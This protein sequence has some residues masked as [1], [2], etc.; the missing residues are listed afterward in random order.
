MSTWL[1]V[2][3]CVVG[4][5]LVGFLVILVISAFDPLDEEDD[6]VFAVATLTLWPLALVFAALFAL[7][8]I[9]WG[10]VKVANYY[11]TRL[12]GRMPSIFGRN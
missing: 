3:A 1:L 6:A 7:V 9:P 5:L 8:A 4:Y 12:G 10:L 11:G 2:T